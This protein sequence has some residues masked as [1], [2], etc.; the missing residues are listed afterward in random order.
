MAIM[1]AIEITK[2]VMK[3]M[4]EEVEAKDERATLKLKLP[5]AIKR[6]RA[7]QQNWPN[8]CWEALSIDG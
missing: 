1:Q 7:I 6:I 8:R 5:L 2:Q 4:K 3:G